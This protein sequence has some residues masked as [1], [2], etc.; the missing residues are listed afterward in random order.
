MRAILPLA[1]T[2]GLALSPGSL[3]AQA[4][5][6]PEPP[7]SGETH[8]TPPAESA[9]AHGT[10]APAGDHGA[11][12][13]HGAAAHHGPEVKLPGMHRAL[14]PGE[15]YTIKLFN[16]AL[17]AGALFFAL[18]GVLSAAF[19]ARAQEL[20]DRLAQAE[21]D[22]AEGEAQVQELEAKMAGLQE[23]LAGILSRAE[24]DAE[25]EKLRVLEA[26]RTEAD[27]I[28]AQARAEIEFQQRHAEQELRALVAELAVQGA[29][30]RL[31]LR[32]QGAEAAPVLDRAIEQVGQR[33]E[34]VKG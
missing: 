25:G 12:A 30:E 18:K 17:F 1:L 5:G 13:G 19:K 9:Q 27:L 7:K 21:K 31:R 20:E 23:E 3:S 24:A 26:A 10:P 22:K 28:L 29:S 4:H 34:G 16:F 6:A 33:A 2:A 11:P 14:S 32:L 8:G 15:Q